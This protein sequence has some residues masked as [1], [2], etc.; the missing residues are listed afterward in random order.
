[1]RN[2]TASATHS[3][4]EARPPAG[5]HQIEEKTL[6][7]TAAID[8]IYCRKCGTSIVRGYSYKGYCAVC[9]KPVIE[10]EVDDAFMERL[11][12][13]RAKSEQSS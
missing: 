12:Q 3:T 2:R 11:L 6:E 7:R 1:M 8:G 10:K 9:A 13:G 4:G 5:G